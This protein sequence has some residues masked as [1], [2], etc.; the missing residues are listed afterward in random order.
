MMPGSGR[1]PGEGNGI[2]LQYSRLENPMDRGAWQA[3]VHRVKESDTTERLNL[4]TYAAYPQP[5]EGGGGVRGSTVGSHS[6]PMFSRREGEGTAGLPGG[7]RCA[8]VRGEAPGGVQAFWATPG[9]LGLLASLHLGPDPF[10]GLQNE[11]C[12]LTH[13][14]SP[15]L[16]FPP[17]SLLSPLSPSCS[18]ISHQ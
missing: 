9:F 14:W 15:P 16:S 10:Q 8:Q 4:P 6:P 2:P 18:G 13:A 3:G 11:G 5:G 7:Q 17:S 12:M 1:S